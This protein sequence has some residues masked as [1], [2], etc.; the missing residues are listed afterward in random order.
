M[1]T[2]ILSW[3]D[4]QK[5]QYFQYTES[6]TNILHIELANGNYKLLGAEPEPSKWFVDFNNLQTLILDSCKIQ[7]IRQN[8]FTSIKNLMVLKLINNPIFSFPSEIRKLVNLHTLVITGS[9]IT[10]I[11]DDTFRNNKNLLYL[12]LENNQIA[13]IF[14]DALRGTKIGYINLYG[15]KLS[16]FFNIPPSVLILNLANNSFKIINR[17]PIHNHSRIEQINLSTNKITKI[18]AYAFSRL[19]ELKIVKLYN[20]PIQIIDVRAFNW[21]PKLR[22]IEMSNLHTKFRPISNSFVTVP[23]LKYIT[24]DGIKIDIK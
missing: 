10:T 17:L 18:E 2:P 19:Q 7:M 20:N 15:N 23:K 1:N 24:I 8:T 12:N 16:T 22:L 3:R 9:K 4:E 11:N 21:C 14:P 5:N 6:K 13:T